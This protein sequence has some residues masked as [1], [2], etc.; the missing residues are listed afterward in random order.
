MRVA[1]GWSPQCKAARHGDWALVALTGSSREYRRCL[2]S[3]VNATFGASFANGRSISRD[4]PLPH[5]VHDNLGDVVQAQLL[6]EIRAVCLDG[7]K[8]DIQ[9]LRCL[10]IRL[11][12]G[13]EL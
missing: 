3:Q 9:H 2:I 5:R 7:M 1:S 6:H 4:N 13:Q 12:F 8:A 10:L 11:A